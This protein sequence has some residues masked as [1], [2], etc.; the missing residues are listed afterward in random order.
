M[1]V[2]LKHAVESLPGAA[3]QVFG[4]DTR[5]RSLGVGRHGS[6]FGYVAVRNASLPVPLSGNVASVL[7]GNVQGIPLTFVDAHRDPASLVKLPH[8]GPGSPS[9]A[10]LVPEQTP[11]VPLVCGLQLENFDD[12]ERTGVIDDGHM[13]V[14]TLGCFVTADGR[15]AMLSNNHVLAGENRGQNG[16]DRIMQP[17]NGEFSLDSQAGTLNNFV[18]L[19]RSPDGAS[20]GQGNVTFNDVDAAIALVRDGVA[21]KQRYL[22]SRQGVVAPNGT[23]APQVGDKVFKVGRTTGLTRGEITQVATVVGPVPYD[24]GPCWFQGTIVIE[25]DNGTMFSDHGDSGSAIV[26]TDGKIVGLLFAGN[27]Q[28]TYGCPIDAV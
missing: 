24:P 28:Q 2:D 21:A 23:A 8:S 27:G 5:V 22:S 17:G 18:V 10:S 6:G 11:Q 16:H 7:P 25:G 19:R 15:K 20:P 1:G 13:I 3:K 4:E 14:G 26:R 9:L 12:D